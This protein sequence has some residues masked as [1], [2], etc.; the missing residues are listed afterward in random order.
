MLESCGRGGVQKHEV[1][2]LR[3][4][5]FK[6]STI[7]N[8]NIIC[9]LDILKEPKFE[10]QMRKSIKNA[11]LYHLSS[12]FVFTSILCES[13]SRYKEFEDSVFLASV[14]VKWHGTIL[15]LSIFFYICMLIFH[16]RQPTSVCIEHMQHFCFVKFRGSRRL[17]KLNETN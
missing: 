6:E 7:F 3:P 4:F 9:E 17:L 13:E 14:G 15:L 5:L 1:S 16:S 8:R 12:F 2:I 11:V 10:A